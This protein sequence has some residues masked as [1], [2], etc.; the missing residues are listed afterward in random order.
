MKKIN[1][2]NYL[3]SII[4]DK[5]ENI[6]IE[7]NK[8]ILKSADFNDEKKIIMFQISRSYYF[9]LLFKIFIQK[10][11]SNYKIIGL[12]TDFI[13]PQKK[14]INSFFEFCMKKI[15]YYF[16]KRKWLILYKSIGINEVYD[17]SKS[18]KG[19]I[20]LIKSQANIIFNKIKKKKDILNIKY[21]NIK[22][23]DLIYD[24]YL[25]FRSK[26]T[27]FLK[28]H[29]LKKI[30][31]GSLNAITII[32]KIIKQKKISAYHSSYSVYVQHGI[33]ARLLLNNNIDVF[34]SGNPLFSSLKKLNK[35]D[36]LHTVS[37]KNFSQ[38]FKKLTNKN[39]K[40]NEAKKEIKKKFMGLDDISTRNNFLPI[41][42]YKSKN[43]Q[44][45]HLSKIQGV[46]FLHDFFDSPH[47][48]GNIIFND[49]YEWA[50]FT[51]DI[52]RKFKL[53]IAIKSHPNSRSESLKINEEL[54]KKYSDLVWI[55][56]DLSNTA[57]FD[58]KN[59][60]FGISC[61]GS[62]LYELAYHGKYA[63]SAG[64]HPSSSFKFVINS[65]SKIDY[66]NNILKIIKIKNYPVSY[67][68]EVAKL[69]YMYFMNDYLNNK[70][71]SLII[72][73]KIELISI[74]ASSSDKLNYYNRKIKQFLNL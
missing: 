28:D 69:Y 72:A 12:W 20:N 22:I 52:I 27:V 47:L 41:N 36:F 53:K 62:V 25:R 14:E 42:T 73:K 51:L 61:Y 30:I 59:I 1:I 43:L 65:K 19:E 44:N 13:W 71:E 3:R 33:P 32:E 67:K 24:T 48:W 18:S 15:Y 66:M 54:K 70:D 2:I 38:D 10:K 17:T 50:V 55:D 21:K 35:I 58:K 5:N 74:D 7:E 37:F 49:F 29:Y 56:K 26:E 40:I 39:K 68:S 45:D 9:L 46:V 11:Y 4:L 57:I 6:F 60:K 34:T 8:K 23:G 31:F 63:I 64:S 16:L